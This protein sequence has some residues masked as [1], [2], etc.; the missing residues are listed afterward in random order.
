MDLVGKGRHIRTVPVPAWVTETLDAWLAAAEIGPPSKIF[1][2]SVDIA[3]KERVCEPGKAPALKRMINVEFFPGAL[4][5]SFP[6]MNA[7]APTALKN[8]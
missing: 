3:A 1:N 8:I 5:R 2:P 6:R 4:K 7:G